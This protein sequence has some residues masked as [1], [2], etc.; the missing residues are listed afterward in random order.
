ML[1]EGENEGRAGNMSEPK[2]PVRKR[3]EVINDLLESIALEETGLAHI[4]NALAEKIQKAI[5]HSKRLE[6]LLEIN[7]SANR[8]LG[9]LIKKEILLEFKLEEVVD[10]VKDGKKKEDWPDEGTG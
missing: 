6:D 7:K 10:L 4:L 8:T 2:I 1:G 5:Q 9:K 3:E